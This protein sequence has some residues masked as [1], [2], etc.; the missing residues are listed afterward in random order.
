M[1]SGFDTAELP[2]DPSPSGEAEPRA[3]AGSGSGADGGGRPWALELFDHGLKKRQKVELLLRMAG[4]LEGV[5]A[6]LVTG[7]DNPGALNWHFR[8]A[9]GQWRWAELEHDRIPAIEALLGERVEHAAPDRLPFEDAAFDLV[10]VI[11]VHE[12]LD[13]VEPLNRELVRLLRPGGRLLVT[14]PSGNTR[15]PLARLKRLLGM[16]P[17]VYG[18]RVQGYTHGELE[19]MARA[20]GLEPVARGAYARFFTESIELAI[21]LAW[22]K[23]LG[24]SPEGKAP[25]EGEIAPSDAA[26]LRKA[27]GAWGLYRR[28]FP[29]IRLVASLDRLIPGRGGYAVAIEARKP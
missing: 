10:V 2:T 12:H 25:K 13:A 28:V 15:L 20:V 14:T 24:R 1:S 17:E 4:N 16:T 27:G 3:G 23:V 18:H 5:R 7:G 21:N 26:G 19:A 22:V 8:A 29:L 11:D 6:L 9:G